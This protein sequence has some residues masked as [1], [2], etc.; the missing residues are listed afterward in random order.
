MWDDRF[1]GEGYLY[2]TDP[3]GFVAAQAGVLPP[4][5]RVLSVADG[6]G[7]NSTYLAGLGHKVTA[8]DASS[9]ALDK[10][11][12]L[13]ATR[14]VAVDFAQVDILAWDWPE[15][16]F[17]A[18]LGVFI[19]F[20]PPGPRAGLHRNLARA[21]R[22]GGL[23]LLHGYAPRQVGYG[24]GGPSQVENLYTLAA[25]RADFAGWDVLH[26]ED[27]DATLREGHGHNG[28]SALIDFIARRPATAGPV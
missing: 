23:V 1:R 14:N 22:P 9:V 7:R 5:A 21:V 3:A 15:A 12:A 17:D 16:A 11:R 8:I 26:A 6:E 19:Q 27:Y 4:A 18:V 24:T 25:L 20:L 28:S 2:G 13:A 10:A